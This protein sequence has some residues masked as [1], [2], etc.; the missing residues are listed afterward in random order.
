MAHQMNRRVKKWVENDAKLLDRMA[1]KA[2]KAA[3]EETDLEYLRDIL[4]D[5]HADL[6]GVRDELRDIISGKKT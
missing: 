2:Q 4:L 1:K 6:E 3:E 5:L